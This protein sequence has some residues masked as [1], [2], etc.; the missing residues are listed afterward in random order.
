MTNRHGRKIE[1]KPDEAQAK[2]EGQD[3]Q[4]VHTSQSLVHAQAK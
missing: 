3:L 4:L 1:P 2:K